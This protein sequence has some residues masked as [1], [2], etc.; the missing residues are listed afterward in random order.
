MPKYPTRAKGTSRFYDAEDTPRP[1]NRNAKP[2]SAK[3]RASIKPGT[4]L[5]LLAGR[6]R[7]KRVVFLKQLESGLLLVTG[8]LSQPACARRVACC[9]GGARFSAAEIFDR[10]H[11]TTV[12]SGHRCRAPRMPGTLRAIDGSRMRAAHRR[13]GRVGGIDP[14]TTVR[15]APM[16]A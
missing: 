14:H 10:R 13:R 2:K 12:A 3:L 9:A 16:V 1:L 11:N 15:V 8:T 7:A 5:I 4:V 6:F